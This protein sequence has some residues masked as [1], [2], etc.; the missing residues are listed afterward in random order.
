MILYEKKKVILET[1][2][3]VFREHAQPIRNNNIISHY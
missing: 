1:V 2:G 3:I